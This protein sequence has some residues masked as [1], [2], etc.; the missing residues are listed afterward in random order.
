MAKQ[1]TVAVQASGLPEVF[2]LCGISPCNLFSKIREGPDSIA[3]D[4]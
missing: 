4:A 2:L 1:Y 3:N